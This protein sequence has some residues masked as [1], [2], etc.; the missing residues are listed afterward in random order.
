MGPPPGI[1]EL[2]GLHVYSAPGFS[3]ETANGGANFEVLCIFF[4]PNMSTYAVRTQLKQL[5]F[6]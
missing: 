5:D 2:P 4:P 1:R 6:E 3:T